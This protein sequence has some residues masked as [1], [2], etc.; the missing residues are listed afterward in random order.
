MACTCRSED[1]LQES[2]L[3][4]S[5]VGAKD[6]TQVMRFC[7]KLLCAVSLLPALLISFLTNDN[8]QNIIESVSRFTPAR[9]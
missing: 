5:P 3:S 2:V 6:Q 9:L 1:S 7:S 4:F 8:K